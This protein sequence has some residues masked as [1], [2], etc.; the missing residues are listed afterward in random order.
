MAKN[1]ES[2]VQDPSKDEKSRAQ[3]LEGMRRRLLALPGQ[4]VLHPDDLKTHLERLEQ[5]ADFGETAQRI[6]EAGYGIR[7]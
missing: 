5:A 6:L 3:R 2:A 4:I 1:Q 7:R